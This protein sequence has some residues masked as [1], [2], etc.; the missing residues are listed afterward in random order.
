M[1]RYAASIADRMGPAPPWWP[2]LVAFA[3]ARHHPGGVLAILRQTA[4]VLRQDPA[5]TTRQLLQNSDSRNQLDDR[6]IRVLTMFFTGNGLALPDDSLQRRARVITLRY[7]DAIAQLLRVAVVEDDRTQHDQRE[8][9]RRT[10]R[11]QLSQLG[12]I[13]S[14]GRRV[15]CA[16]LVPRL[17]VNKPDN[18]GHRDPSLDDGSWLR[19]R[20]RGPALNRLPLRPMRTG[21]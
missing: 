20:R 17:P 21:R 1:F 5:V 12:S 7:L 10:G 8:R 18:K 2:E 6:T 9:N 11:H 16:V 14:Q 15:G 4:R 19:G 3:A 13:D